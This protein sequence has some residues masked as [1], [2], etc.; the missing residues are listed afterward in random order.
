MHDD[1]KTLAAQLRARLDTDGPAAVQAALEA[2][3]AQLTP[4]QRA[5]L[6]QMIFGA[7]G[8]AAPPSAAETSGTVTVR[9]GAVHGPVTGVNQGTII[10]GAYNRIETLGNLIG[11]D[12]VAGDQVA[13]DQGAGDQGAGDKLQID[14][15]T[16]VVYTGP[17]QPHN[18]EA[19]RAL[20]QAYRS[21][22]AAH[23]A[24]W[25][26]MR[27]CRSRQP[28]SHCPRRSGSW[29]ARI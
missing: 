13:G 15:L 21:E 18:P 4:D 12:Q 5:H 8:A 24:V 26:A 3:A 2:Q 23:Y 16:L 22:V 14:R 7:S 10:Q 25:R 11:G 29:S 19:R 6:E 9:G 17:A 1:L 28:P 20:E 27:P